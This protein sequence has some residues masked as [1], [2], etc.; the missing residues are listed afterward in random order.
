MSYSKSIFNLTS[1]LSILFSFNAF[2]KEEAK[3]IEPITVT[4]NPLERSSN[5]LVQPITTLSGDDLL[6][7]LQPTIGETL[8]QEPGIR[9]SYYGPEQVGL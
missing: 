8:S 3:R 2:S 5:E 9:S 4:A 6:N 1:A 7:K